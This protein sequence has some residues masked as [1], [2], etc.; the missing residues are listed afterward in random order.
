MTV[1]SRRWNN[2]NANIENLKKK[3]ARKSH[4]LCSI[5][6]QSPLKRIALDGHSTHTKLTTSAVPTAAVL[7]PAVKGSSVSTPYS[8]ACC[9]FHAFATGICAKR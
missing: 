7:H 6:M 3:N 8:D 2:L 4:T 9:I 5:G 1:K